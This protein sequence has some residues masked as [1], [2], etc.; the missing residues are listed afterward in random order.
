MDH[1]IPTG[2]SQESPRANAV[3]SSSGHRVKPWKLKTWLLRILVTLA[4]VLVV[5]ELVAR[6]YFGLGDPPLSMADSRIEYLFQPNQTCSRFGNRIHYNAF[7]MRSD[8]FP[9][10]KSDRHEVRILFLGDSI[11]NGGALTDQANLATARLQQRL[12]HEMQ[13]PVVVGNASAGSWGPPN[14]L[15]YVEQWGFFD[16]DV[17]VLI[18][19]SHDYA[20]AP[21]FASVVG[22]SPN[23]PDHKPL[24]ALQEVVTRYL[25][26]YLLQIE[27]NLSDSRGKLP[28][29]SAKTED[30]RL[31]LDCEAQIIRRTREAGAVPVVAQHWVR[32]E[33]TGEMEPGHN[34]LKDTANRQGAIVVQLGPAFANSINNGLNPYRDPLHPNDVGQQLIADTLFPVIKRAICSKKQ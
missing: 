28:P 16:A 15:A 34:L 7:S 18:L 29:S 19:S 2:S 32:G 21:T 30:I 13:R 1:H 9:L 10:H 20:D 26:R 22:L 33:L 24:F 3:S 12:A 4:I 25:P 8:D 17:V 27:R 6:Y 31:C 11:I 5:G 23:F 14:E